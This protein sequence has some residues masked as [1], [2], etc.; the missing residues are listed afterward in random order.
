[1]SEFHAYLFG[2]YAYMAYFMFIIYNLIPKQE[3]ADCL[4]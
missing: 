4:C 1:V 3:L 2:L